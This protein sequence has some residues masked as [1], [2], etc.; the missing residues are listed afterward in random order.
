[1]TVKLKQVNVAVLFV[2]D[3]ERSKA[4]Y[5]D[6]LGIPM[7]FADD[8]S[9]GFDFDPVLLILLTVK[10]ARELLSDEAVG[11]PRPS[12]AS[13]QLVSFVDDVDDIYEEL[14]AKGVEFIRTPIDREWGLRTAHFK[15]P[16]GN[17]WEIAQPVA[18]EPAASLT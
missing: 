1:V 3:L 10:G 4:F 6:T 14:V 12:G 5:R 15:D 2:T 16:D 11:D 13:S 9:A 17:V 7:K 18:K 8:A